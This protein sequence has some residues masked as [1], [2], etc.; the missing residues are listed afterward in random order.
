MIQNKA[1]LKEYMDADLNA[2]YVPKK[3]FPRFLHTLHGNECCHAYRYV[4]CLR[5]TEYHLNINNFIRFHWYR[6]KLSRLALRYGI[7]T[8][9]NAIGK[10]LNIIHLAGGGGC[11][12]NCKSMGDYCRVQSGVVI[13]NVGDGD[14]RPTIGNYV[15][16]GLGCKVYGK[17]TIG[18]GAKILPNAVV[19]K[20]VP[21]YT[22]VG[23]VPAKMI[24][25]LTEGE[26]KMLDSYRGDTDEEI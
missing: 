7:R 4:R 23:G 8:E 24:R 17:I 26:I 6:L 16:F 13:G 18:D 19:T 9:I 2:A 15:G 14:H 12:L 22:I 3:W 5:L 21:S 25:K 20:D 11:I 10:G 1:D